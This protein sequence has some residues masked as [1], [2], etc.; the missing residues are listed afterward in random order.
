ML[1]CLKTKVTSGS[2]HAQSVIFCCLS[3]DSSVDEREHGF[4]W[5][6]PYCMLYKVCRDP[7]TYPS[8]G[9][10]RRHVG[11]AHTRMAVDE[12]CPSGCMAPCGGCLFSRAGSPPA[13]CTWVNR[14]VRRNLLKLR[15]LFFPICKW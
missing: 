8:L 1:K 9:P 7:I 13:A 15:H 14:V 12:V 6:M 5:Q 4:K 3:I 10:A 2:V 11:A